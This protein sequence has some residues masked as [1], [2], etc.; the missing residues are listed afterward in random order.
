MNAPK[1]LPAW[2]AWKATADNGYDAD[3]FPVWPESPPWI[4]ID[5]KL[6]PAVVRC[7]L[8]GHT[9]ELPFG[10]ITEFVAIVSAWSTK[11]TGCLIDHDE[12][13]AEGQQ[14][15]IEHAKEPR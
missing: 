13:I 2:R 1:I 14:E 12:R 5:G 11:H 7:V 8:C 10:V 4:F 3:G 15:A 6:Q 9:R